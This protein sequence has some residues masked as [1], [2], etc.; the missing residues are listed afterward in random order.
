LDACDYTIDDHLER[1]GAGVMVAVPQKGGTANL[2]GGIYRLNALHSRLGRDCVIGIVGDRYAANSN[3]KRKMD[4]V[5]KPRS[6]YGAKIHNASGQVSL[7]GSL[8]SFRNTQ[9]IIRRNAQAN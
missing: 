9:R 4:V 2:F 1:G 7:V 8:K 5:T 6:K 3:N